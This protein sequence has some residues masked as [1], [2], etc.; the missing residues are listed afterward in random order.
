M[1]AATVDTTH[2]RV[3]VTDLAG[4]VLVDDRVDVAVATGPQRTLDA[5][6][7]PR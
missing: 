2:T 7:A 6:A 4:R 1:L 3:A 5:I